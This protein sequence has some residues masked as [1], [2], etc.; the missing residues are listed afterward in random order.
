MPPAVLSPSCTQLCRQDILVS[1]E[2]AGGPQSVGSD[3]A[4]GSV[5][6]GALM[7]ASQQLPSRVLDQRTAPPGEAVAGLHVHH[8]AQRHT[9]DTQHVLAEQVNRIGADH[10]P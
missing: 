1:P 7:R 10:V 3:P 8:P 2:Q 5:F 9:A 6:P 4:T